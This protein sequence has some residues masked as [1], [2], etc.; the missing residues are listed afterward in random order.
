METD[1]YRFSEAVK[2]WI[3]ASTV[4]IEW[5]AQ[6]RQISKRAF[7]PYFKDTDIRQIKSIHIQTFYAHLKAKGYSAK[8]CKNL[9]GELRCLFRFFKKSLPELPDFPKVVVQEPL[10]D[11]LEEDDQDRIF[12]FVPREDLPIFEFLRHYGT[13]INEATG[14]LRESVNLEK[15]Y[16]A[17][18]TALTRKRLKPTVKTKRLQLL[19]IIPETRW[20]FEP[21]GNDGKSPFQFSKNG[22]PYSN[23]KL[24]RIWKE[25]NRRSGEK[26]V[27]RLY[28]AMRHSWASQRVNQG[29]N[30]SEIGEVLNHSSPKTTMR[31]AKFNLKRLE[32]VVRGRRQYRIFVPHISDMS[33][34]LRKGEKIRTSVDGA[35]VHSPTARRPPSFSRKKGRLR[36]LPMSTK[37]AK[38]ECRF[39]LS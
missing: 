24:N 20:L 37:E 39:V 16:F 27:V 19:P 34:M 2:T 36:F 13:R 23:K 30:L 1:I 32:T 21:N 38:K 26:K 7:V 33:D 35:R 5:L 12:N 8:Y 18:R 31:Y 10:I 9:L 25:A 6:R 15:G 17:L 11:W 22:I 4:S 14:L 29:F 28:C 3:G